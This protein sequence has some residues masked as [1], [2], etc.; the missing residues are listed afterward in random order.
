M[1]EQSSAIGET[2][3]STIVFPLGAWYVEGDPSELNVTSR[4]VKLTSA[5]PARCPD[6]KYSHL[7]SLFFVGV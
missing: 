7:H 2:G 5:C 4:I 1:W 3:P 6:R